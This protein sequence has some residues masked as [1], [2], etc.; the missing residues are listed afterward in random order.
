MKHFS[1]LS[2]AGAVALALAGGATASA[3]QFHAFGGTGDT[4]STT[5]TSGV[6]NTVLLGQGPVPG[7]LISQSNKTAAGMIAGFDARSFTQ[8]QRER[9][10]TGITLSGGLDAQAV[11]GM[12][13]LLHARVGINLAGYFLPLGGFQVI[14]GFALGYTSGMTG[15]GGNLSRV[16]VTPALSIAYKSVRL[17]YRQSPW[18]YG[19]GN[20]APRDVL[21]HLYFD[22]LLHN[23]KGMGVLTLGAVIPDT[24][25]SVSD[26]VVVA[27]KS[28]RLD[29]FGVRISW[30]GGLQGNTPSGPYNPA[31]PWD[32]YSRGVTVGASY[33]F[34]KGVSVGIFEGSQ[35]N[36]SG[37]MTSTTITQVA[38]SGHNVGVTLSDWF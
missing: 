6:S 8:G 15:N 38:T 17:T 35:S 1:M 26:G 22:G 4:S 3:V 5:S 32:S 13:A 25:G 11:N 21:A 2:L 20:N 7:A 19:N 14:P 31:R 34:H 18:S 12:Q 23:T 28:P 10:E 30:V 9:G 16:R 33:H 29:G 24:T 37:S 27:V 36:S